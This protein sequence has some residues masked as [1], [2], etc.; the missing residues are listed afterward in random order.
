MKE[1]YFTISQNGR[2]ILQTAISDDRDGMIAL[3][4][5]LIRQFPASDGFE[6]IE[7]VRSAEWHTHTIENARTLGPNDSRYRK[8]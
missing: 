8:A 3:R 1:T 2:F 4:E 7:H 5:I 6:I